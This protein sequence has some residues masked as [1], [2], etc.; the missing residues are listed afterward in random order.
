MTTTTKRDK[1]KMDEEKKITN[2]KLSLY[3]IK[4]KILHQHR[5]TAYY[6]GYTQ[7]NIENT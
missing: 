4:D 3:A 1:K 2:L 5:I 6:C 7:P